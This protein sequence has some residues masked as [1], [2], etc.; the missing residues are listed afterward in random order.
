MTYEAIIQLI[1]RNAQKHKSCAEEDD[2]HWEHLEQEPLL[3]VF[4]YCYQIGIRVDGYD[5]RKI[6]DAEDDADDGVP[7]EGCREALFSL[8]RRMTD[9]DCSDSIEVPLGVKRLFEH[10]EKSFWPDFRL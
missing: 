4:E 1:D 6:L 7:P 3:A 10:Y 2:W 9:S 8:Q 5:I